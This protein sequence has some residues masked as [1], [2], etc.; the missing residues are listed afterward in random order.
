MTELAL[1]KIEK[2]IHFSVNDPTKNYD[3]D[4]KKEIRP[5]VKGCIQIDPK[6]IKDGKVNQKTR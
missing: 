5:Y 2:K 3:P 1:R 6:Q 4:R